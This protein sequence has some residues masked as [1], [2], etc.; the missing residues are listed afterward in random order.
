[1]GNVSL[2]VLEKS[3]NFFLFKKATNPEWI[4]LYPV[5]KATGFPNSYLLDNDD[6]G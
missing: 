1:M 5:D 4:N 2:K 6:S 3:L